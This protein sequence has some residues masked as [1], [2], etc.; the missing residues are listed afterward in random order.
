[1]NQYMESG[2][3]MPGEGSPPQIMAQVKTL[4]PQ[5]LESEL[6]FKW[7]LTRPVYAGSFEMGEVVKPTARMVLSLP[8]FDDANVNRAN[9]F[10]WASV[11]HCWA[12]YARRVIQVTL[13]AVKAP[14][15]SKVQVDFSVLPFLK[16]KDFDTTPKAVAGDNY[17]RRNYTYEWSIDSELEH[18]I[19]IPRFMIKGWRPSS[20]SPSI[21]LD[22]KTGVIKPNKI[23]DVNRFDGS[24]AFTQISPVIGGT[25][26]PSKFKILVFVNYSGTVVNTIVS[27]S[28][29]TC[30]YTIKGKFA[31]TTVK[32][33]LLGSE[34]RRHVEGFAHQAQPTQ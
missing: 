2:V 34:M 16:S 27:P 22:S 26:F 15:Q 10:A 12:R 14:T 25:I 17:A 21:H 33:E 1:M 20:Q 5:N 23:S 24:L 9:Q 4:T 6:T 32:W 18:T 31:A 3:S 8:Y 13:M 28:D 19:Q 7:M 30:G 11:P 29:V